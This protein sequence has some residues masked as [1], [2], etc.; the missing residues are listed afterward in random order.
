MDTD[1]GTLT[2]GTQ[3]V[4]HPWAESAISCPGTVYLS[5]QLH[6]RSEGTTGDSR[7]G[8]LPAAHTT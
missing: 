2:V 8:W 4:H 7:Q 3:V 1:M 6:C 5:C